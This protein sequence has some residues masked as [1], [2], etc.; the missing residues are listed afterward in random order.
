MVLVTDG[1]DS[2]LGLNW[3]PGSMQPRP[4]TASPLAFEDVA[5]ELAA[6]GVELYIISTENRPTAMTMAWLAAH[7]DQVLVSPEARRM[8]MPQYT[9][10]LAEMVQAGR[11]QPV[12]S[13]RTGRLGRG[14]SPNC[15]GPRRGIHA[16]LLPAGRSRRARAGGPCE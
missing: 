2:G 13:A 11:R 3:D 4:G 5:R 12:F 6:E 9:L 16:G 1:Q 7:R 14:L 15:A 10:Y 8:G